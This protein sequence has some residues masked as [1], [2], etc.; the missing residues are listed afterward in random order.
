VRIFSRFK[1]LFMT[2]LV[3]RYHDL[4]KD[5]KTLGAFIETAVNSDESKTA[6]S[7]ESGNPSEINSLLRSQEKFTKLHVIKFEPLL[8]SN[9]RHYFFD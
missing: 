2:V 3:E 5:C 6:V 9:E 8:P 7:A 1:S 4:F